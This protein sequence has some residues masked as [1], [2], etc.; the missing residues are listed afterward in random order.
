MTPERE[1][2]IR[3]VVALNFG[4]GAMMCHAGQ[5]R[6]E[7]LEALD[8]TRAALHEACDMLDDVRWVNDAEE[9]RAAK[10]R[11]RAIAGPR[12]DAGKEPG[13][14]ANV[15]REPGC[16]SVD[17]DVIGHG[18]GPQPFPEDPWPYEDAGKEPG[19]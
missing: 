14:V 4:C 9:M 6:S 17:C 13:P 10:V 8:E 19:R 18:T 12:L 1:A 3:H 15:C 2:R 7:L 11:L 5:G 16:G